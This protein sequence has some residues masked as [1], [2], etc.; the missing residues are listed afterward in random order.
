MNGIDIYTHLH[1]AVQN[2]PVAIKVG[3]FLS[4][5]AELYTAA[6]TYRAFRK[7]SDPFIHTLLIFYV[8]AIC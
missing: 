2:Y 7:Y 5:D 1:D 4:K 3:F 6:L 8:A